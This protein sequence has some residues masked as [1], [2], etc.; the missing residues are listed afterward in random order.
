M[1]GL[2]TAVN[3]GGFVSA[4]PAAKLLDTYSGAA[5]A[6][7]LRQLSNSYSG[8][9][10]KVRRASD[11]AE[12]DIS[13]SNGELDTSAISTH[14][15]S[16][17]GFISVWYDQSGNL[18]NATQS[19]A[20]SQPKIH[21]ATTGVLTENGKPAIDF[22]GS[23]DQL[24]SA[25]TYTPTTSM[26]QIVVAKGL[27]SS[28]DQIIGDTSD[29]KAGMSLRIQNGDFNYFNGTT[30][31][32]NSLTQTANDNQNLHFYGRDTSS[33]FYAR[34]NGSESSTSI[35]AINT[36]AQNIYLAARHDGSLDLDGTMQ[37]YVL[38]L[39]SQSA[40]K[41]AIEAEINTFYSIF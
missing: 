24:F 20:A 23:N 27:S 30:S 39:T 9:T 26:A 10:V 3:R 17:D 37:E 33:N 1:L 38:Y 28:V 25:S 7:S 12:L 2:G 22:D 5:A 34:L 15:G 13:F 29:R 41:T 40:N 14:C 11:N 35:S 21:D 31:S 6:Y 16:S 18:N 8:N 32:F 4:A 19:T 36:T